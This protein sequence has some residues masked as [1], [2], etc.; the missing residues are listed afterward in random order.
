MRN[1]RTSQTISEPYV[2]Y[3][4]TCRPCTLQLQDLGAARDKLS[5]AQYVRATFCK[6]T[7][8]VCSV[9]KREEF[10][11]VNNTYMAQCTDINMAC[12]VGITS[13]CV[14]KRCKIHRRWQMSVWC[15][16]T[17]PYDGAA[18]GRQLNV[19]NLVLWCN[20]TC[21]LPIGL[22]RAPKT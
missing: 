15:K 20:N 18:Q 10:V 5:M 4:L 3:T 12:M 19:L 11:D 17:H 8:R 13:T 14:A 9:K 1:V 7:T 21:R 2:G 22:R 16:C 6:Q